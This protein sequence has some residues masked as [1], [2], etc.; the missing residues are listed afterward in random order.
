METG[1]YPHHGPSK[2]PLIV[3]S[4]KHDSRATA[5]NFK[6]TAR[7]RGWS[8]AGWHWLGV[9]DAAAI[10]LQRLPCRPQS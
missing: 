7:R 4:G 8:T 5:V 6:R 10:I 9:V 2:Q 3:Q 1:L